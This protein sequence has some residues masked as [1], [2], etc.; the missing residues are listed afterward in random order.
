MKSK[1]KKI[2]KKKEEK[3]TIEIRELYKRMLMQSQATQHDKE[4]EMIVTWIFLF[5]SLTHI[6]GLLFFMTIDHIYSRF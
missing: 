2:R 4:K 1:R 5:F 3:K 6:L